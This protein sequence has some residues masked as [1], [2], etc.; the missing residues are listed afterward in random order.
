MLVHFINLVSAARFYS[1]VTQCVS[2]IY[3]N[4]LYSWVSY[5]HH[6]CIH[7]SVIFISPST[8]AFSR[9]TLLQTSFEE[10]GFFYEQILIIPKT[11]FTCAVRLWYKFMP[12]YKSFSAPCVTAATPWS[13]GA[14]RTRYTPNWRCWTRT[15]TV[16]SNS[17][18]PVG[19][20]NTTT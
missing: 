2:V 8:H 18:L 17:H 7:E 20:R 19:R 10:K 6:L 11:I 1:N 5:I 9:T 4:Q 16:I 13:E 12:C 3:I 14:T 15:F